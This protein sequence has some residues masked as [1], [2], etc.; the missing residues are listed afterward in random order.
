M[1][2]IN[3]R[4]GYVYVNKGTEGKGTLRERERLPGIFMNRDCLTSLLL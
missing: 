4:G 2:D 3:A 1:W